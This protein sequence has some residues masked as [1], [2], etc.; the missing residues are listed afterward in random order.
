MDPPGPTSPSLGA[1]SLF[2]AGLPVAPFIVSVAL[3]VSSFPAGAFLFAVRDHLDSGDR[4]AA[5]AP[6]FVAVVAVASTVSLTFMAHD[7]QRP[8]TRTNRETE[9]P[10]ASRESPPGRSGYNRFGYSDRRR[11]ERASGRIGERV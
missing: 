7:R 10:P 11:R 5:G 3:G 4:A 8:S 9:N 2:A 1:A 6:I